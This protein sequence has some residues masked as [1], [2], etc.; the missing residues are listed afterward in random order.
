VPCTDIRFLVVEDHEFQR[1]VIAQLL[2][3]LGASEVHL[4][5]DGRS[6]LRVLRD[7]DRP[8]DIVVTDLSMPG[9]DGMEFIRNLSD[10][11][12][13][14]RLIL[15]SALEPDLLGAI[16]HMARAYNMQ[17]LGVMTKPPTAAK[18][19]P[20]IEQFRSGMPASIGLENGFGLEDIADA[21]AHDEFEAWLEPRADLTSGTVRS[22]EVVPRWRHAVH[23]TLLPEDFMPS[24]R[25]RGLNDD[26]V[27]L[28]VKKAAAECRRLQ[29]AG[30]D[31]TVSVNLA[32][33][34]LADPSIAVRVQHIVDAAGVEPRR[35]VLSVPE[36][37]L[38]TGSAKTLENLARL[39]V[40]GFG[41]AVDDFG[42]G[43]MAVEQLSLV[44]FTELK[45]KSSF[46][47]GAESD[48]T[49]RA[50]LAAGLE[51]A[52]R[53]RLKTIASGVST[54]D[55]WA[56]LRHWGCD[57]GQGPFISPPL[58][59]EAFPAWLAHRQGARIADA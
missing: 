24:V 1:R 7:T 4:A 29:E 48:G 46:V 20:L 5:E 14:V 15:V 58:Q 16:A 32:F 54:K 25:A 41:V 35:V 31:L 40:L 44:A 22:F 34:N 26:F 53:L 52:Q 50:G 8:V 33:E 18:L 10:A 37:A 11:G 56:L 30:H 27:W 59:P 21:W 49:A 38:N 6:A 17:L 9:M 51:I 12:T 47:T 42:S 36:A 13:R 45:I 3:T 39:R 43:P 2:K 57:M 28:M 55:E 19:V 23:G